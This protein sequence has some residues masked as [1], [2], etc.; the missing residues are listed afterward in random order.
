MQDLRSQ[1]HSC[2]YDGRNEEFK[3]AV[4]ACP[5]DPCIMSCYPVA[6]S[7]HL[8]C[9]CLFMGAAFPTFVLRNCAGKERMRDL[10]GPDERR[11]DESS[12][13]FDTL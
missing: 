1:K 9:P 7:L 5:F 12:A 13:S 3:I 4:P 6:C 8:S 2:Y 11:C 10:A